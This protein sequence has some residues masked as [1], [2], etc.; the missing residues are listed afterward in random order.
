MGSAPPLA[1]RIGTAGQADVHWRAI[2][3]EGRS[4]PNNP[5]GKAWKTPMEWQRLEAFRHST[6]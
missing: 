1:S 6:G 2:A 3:W 4:R 5:C